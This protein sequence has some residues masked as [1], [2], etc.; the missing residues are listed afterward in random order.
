V[1][2]PEDVILAKLFFFVQGRSAKH[3]SDIAGVLRVSAGQLDEPYIETWV[4]RLGLEEAWHAARGLAEDVS[5][6]RRCP[7]GARQ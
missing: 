4:A 2:T 1:A 3:L 6:M 5:G 7:E